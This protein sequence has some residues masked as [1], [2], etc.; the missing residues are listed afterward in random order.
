M[1]F[2]EAGRFVGCDGKTASLWTT[3]YRQNGNLKDLPRSG[4]PC[5]IFAG[6]N[7]SIINK[8]ETNREYTVSIVGEEIHQDR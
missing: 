7:A 3:R 2:R 1:S 8:A 6:Q 4:P 5:V